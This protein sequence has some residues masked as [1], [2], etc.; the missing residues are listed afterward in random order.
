LKLSEEE[1]NSINE[2]I[3]VEENSYQWLEEKLQKKWLTQPGLLW[4]HN[5]ASEKAISVL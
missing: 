1:R 5:V 2:N 4:N 3:E